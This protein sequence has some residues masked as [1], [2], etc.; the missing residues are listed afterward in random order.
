[1]LQTSKCL[2]LPVFFAARIATRSVTFKE[3]RIWIGELPWLLKWF[4]IFVLLR[5]LV[6]NLYFLKDVSPLISPPYIVGVLTPIL[7]VAAMLT[8]RPPKFIALDKAYLYWSA[9]LVLGALFLLFFDPL[10]LLSI[11]FVL[12]LTMPVYLF[13][14]LRRFITDLRDLHGV[15]T[16]FLYSGI[17]VAGLLL[18]ELVVNPI[19]VEASRGLQRIQA[20][21]G[22]VVSYG[23][24]ITFSLIVA[25]YFFFSRQHLVSFSKR[26]LLLG[27]VGVLALLA[28]VNI[29]HTATYTVFL[30]L[31]LLFLVFNLQAR[32]RSAAFGLILIIGLI[33]FWWGSDLV[34][35]KLTPLVE[36]DIEV[37]TGSQDS[38]RLLHGRVGRWRIML[39]QFSGE[40]VMVQFFGYPLKFTS[41]YQF[42]GIGSHNDFV[43]VLFATGIVGLAIYIYF[44]ISVWLRI[45]VLPIAQRYLLMTTFAALLFYSISVTPTFY[46]PFMYFALSI[47]AFAALPDHKLTQWRNRAY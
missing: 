36:T 45:R 40:S 10:S 22:D 12:K 7:A 39:D 16:S 8:Y 38:D 17:F 3:W 24:Y 9:I 23:M 32:N 28:L 46:A 5:P 33:S 1:M 19:G 34:A 2:R 25:S 37:Y 35:E 43:R 4:P 21:F 30:L 26:A 41:V 29:H 47:F 27:V 31:V 14:F 11:E 20:S 6:D 15:L 42:I 18:F 44:L 13:F